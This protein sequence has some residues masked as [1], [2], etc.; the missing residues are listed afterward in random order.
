MTQT[1]EKDW[2][3]LAEQVVLEKDPKRLMELAE[4]LSE[5]L[6][7]KDSVKDLRPADG[8]KSLIREIEPQTESNCDP[9]ITPE[10]AP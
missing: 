8:S 2:R 3:E 7:A 4:Q 10:S 9:D 6:A 1:E 5:A